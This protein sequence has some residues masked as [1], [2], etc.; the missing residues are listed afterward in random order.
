M[1]SCLKEERERREE[2]ER[3]KETREKRKKGGRPWWLTSVFP[4]FQLKL[5]DYHEF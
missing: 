3:E 1:K 5:G 2:G 4:A